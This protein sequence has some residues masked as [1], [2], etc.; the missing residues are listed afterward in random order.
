MNEVKQVRVAIIKLLLYSSSLYY[1]KGE[2][3]STLRRWELE[4][5]IYV[6]GSLKNAIE[7]N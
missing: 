3:G 6:I 7:G 1:C 4:A 2:L 5:L